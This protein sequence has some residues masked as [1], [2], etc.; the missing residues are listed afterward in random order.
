MQHDKRR[1]YVGIDGRILQSCD[2]DQGRTR[3]FEK[4]PCVGLVETEAA[5]TGT[6]DQNEIS[7]HEQQKSGVDFEAAAQAPRDECLPA[8]LAQGAAI[9]EHAGVAGH[10]DKDFGG[11]AET[12]VAK[13]QPFERVTG[14]MVN[15]D[16]Q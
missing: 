1:Q 5:A 14:N 4:E 9:G 3:I 7:D 11:I 15:K 6:P 13:R 12:V 10:E 16:E 2:V 8:L